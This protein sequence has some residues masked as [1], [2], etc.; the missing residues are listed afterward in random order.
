LT[1]SSPFS[2]SSFGEDYL[3]LPVS[4]PLAAAE[5][6]SNWSNSIPQAT[7]GWEALAPEY[8]VVIDLEPE[9]LGTCEQEFCE[10]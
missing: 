4:Y 8:L 9:V 6:M 5:Q 7:V 10:V 3:G 1:A 2:L